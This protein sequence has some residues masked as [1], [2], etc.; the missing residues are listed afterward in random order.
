MRVT[1]AIASLKHGLA[2]LHLEHAK[3]DDH[4]DTQLDQGH[5]GPYAGCQIEQ[6]E[7][8]A[9]HFDNLRIDHILIS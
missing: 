2:H 1:V 6:Q 4:A 5:P 3:M 9:S 8:L 7:D